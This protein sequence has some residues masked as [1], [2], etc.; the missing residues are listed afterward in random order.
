MSYPSQANLY[1]DT[2]IV[3]HADNGGE[4]MT[5]FCGGNN[6]PLRGGKFSNFEGGIRVNAAVGGVGC[7][8][9]GGE[10]RRKGW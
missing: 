7:R 6:Y 1:D 2:L 5:T 3:L 10:T 4:I 9:R 8:R